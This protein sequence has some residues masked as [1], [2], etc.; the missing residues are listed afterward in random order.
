[1]RKVGSKIVRCLWVDTGNRPGKGSA[2]RKIGKGFQVFNDRE[3]IILF[4]K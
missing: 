3:V 1:M 4:F 2:K